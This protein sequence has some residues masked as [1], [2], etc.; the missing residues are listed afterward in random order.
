MSQR[1]SGQNSD[2]SQA[3]Q[4]L[5]VAKV[6][7]GH[8]LRLEDKLNIT[9]EAMDIAKQEV[10]WRASVEGP[11][12]E[13]LSVRRQLNGALQ[14]G[15]LPVLGISNV[16]LSVTKPENEEAYRLYLRSQDSAYWTTTGNKEGIALLERSVALDAGYAPAWLALGWH[17]YGDADFVNGSEEAYKKSI[18]AFDKARQLDPGLLAASTATI[19]NRLYYGG[20]LNVAFAQIQELA[21]E[22]PKRPEV[23]LILAGAFRVAGALDQA[24]RECE[25]TRQIDSQFWTDCFVLYIHM[26][27]FT[28]AKQEI[29]RSPGDFS[30]FMLGQVLLREGKVDEALPKLKLVSAGHSYELINTCW[31]DSSTP[32]CK[33]VARKLEVE[34]RN[35]PD[36]D[37]WYFAAAMFAFLGD[38]EAAVRLLEADSKQGFCVYPSV[39]R[40]PMFDRI[41]NSKEFLAARQSGIE[42]Q[43]KFA[44]YANLQIQ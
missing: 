19:G 27:D 4:Q 17:Y 24:A 9:L 11:M 13:M 38:K 5:R 15:L 16:E 36:E 22:H 43:Q 32:A 6:I 39:D 12:N 34:C 18:T 21:H 30:S 3:G 40:D 42:C 28:K 41:R 31:P 29:E 35:I 44:H 33:A 23:H 26:G 10:V 2:P 7:V 37:A 1:F 8:F 25:I 20:D 14:K